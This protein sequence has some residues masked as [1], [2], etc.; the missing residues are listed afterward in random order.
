MGSV[1][2][3]QR[4]DG[5]V[6]LQVAI[7]FVGGFHDRFLQER[8]ILASL[9]HPGI[10]RLLDAGRTQLGQPYLVMEYVEGVPIHVYSEN[11]PWRD[12]LNLFLRVCDAI[13]YSHRNLIIHR[14]LKPSN[15][16]VQSDG[17]PKLLDFGIAKII[18]NQLEAAATRERL[19][20]PEYATPEQLQGTARNTATDIF[21]LGMILHRL[22]TGRFPEHPLARPE[23][24]LPHDLYFVLGKALRPE[25]TERY[26]SV[27]ALMMDIRAV[28][29]SRPV[30]ARSGDAWYRT[31]KFARRHWLPVTAAAAVILSLG[32]GL[33]VANRERL[34]AEHRH[35]SPAGNRFGLDGIS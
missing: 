18:D 28:L 33:F 30:E 3:A 7:K 22:L 32:I 11:L 5:E 31:R 9:N 26:A 35:Q 17:S 21:S 16:L 4:T 12:K 34:T 6:D 13:S 2:L 15:I 19:L 29:E 20:T 10:A 1:Y 24:P 23:S 8:Q 25:P 14:D 27:D